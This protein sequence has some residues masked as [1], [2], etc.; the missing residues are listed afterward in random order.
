MPKL[1]IFALNGSVKELE[2]INLRLVM[3]K[4]LKSTCSPDMAYL[5]KPEYHKIVYLILVLCWIGLF[6]AVEAALASSLSS[7]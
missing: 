6:S 2:D 5:M 7:S 3:T 1:I 4:V